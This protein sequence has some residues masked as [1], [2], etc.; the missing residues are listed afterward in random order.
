MC[1]GVELYSNLL[2]LKACKT[3]LACYWNLGG[4]NFQPTIFYSWL[5]R[6][7]PSAL[8]DSGQQNREW[9]A[10][11]PMEIAVQRNLPDMFKILAEFTEIPD[12]VKLL[13]LSK[14]MQSSSDNVENSKEEFQSILST[15]PA[16]LVSLFLAL[17]GLLAFFR[18]W[19]FIAIEFDWCW[20]VIIDAAW[21][22]FLGEHHICMVWTPGGRGCL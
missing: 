12:K 19:A 13:Q 16:D 1:A 22:W 3:L 20:L 10:D 21:C 17:P 11:T 14:M 6:V 9:T 4:S 8:P 5:L 18:F 7:D 15:L 2:C